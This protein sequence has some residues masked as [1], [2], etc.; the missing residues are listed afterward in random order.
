MSQDK[1]KQRSRLAALRYDVN[2]V[3]LRFI[4]SS[5]RQANEDFME[6][7]TVGKLPE[8]NDSIMRLI[9]SKLPEGSP[10]LT[11]DQVYVHFHEAA[12]NNFVSDRSM[13]M[14]EK[15]LK[16]IGQ[17][18]AAGVAFMNSHRTGGM[19][20][21]SELPF[22][23]TF[24][25]QYQ[26][27]F[28]DNKRPIR[29]SIIGVYMLKGTHP[30][31]QNGPSTDDLH[32]G[33]LSGTIFDISVGLSGGEYICEVCSNPLNARDDDGEYL[34]NH[35]PGT[36]MGMTKE[37]ILAQKKADPQNTKGLASYLLDDAHLNESSAVYDGAVPGA[38]IKK[39]MSFAQSSSISKEQF[40]ELVT[41][42]YQE[43]G[44][45]LPF[46]I[47]EIVTLNLEGDC[48]TNGE[49]DTIPSNG[50]KF[51]N[52][53]NQNEDS[54]EETQEDEVEV[55]TEDESLETPDPAPVAEAPV[56]ETAPV[57]GKQ[58]NAN[59]HGRAAKYFVESHLLSNRIL[60]TESESLTNLYLAC[61]EHGIEDELEAFVEARPGHKFTND[62]IAPRLDG[63]NYSTPTLP[64]DAEDASIEQAR[65]D[66]SKFLNGDKAKV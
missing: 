13:H 17:D 39:V 47:S 56:V 1:C 58:N 9:N 63:K 35:Y 11:S 62:V 55:V 23:R 12:N 7:K 60:P 49:H 38:G 44:S 27:G 36:H 3:P 51:M 61:A 34:C 5:T 31:G 66:T 45:L 16:N 22:G 21:P 43:F 18:A 52:N 54:Q 4:G 50:E 8:S 33:I 25:G 40:R 28:D 59:K 29:R 41:E 26:E 30:N 2:A 42:A 57:A 37:E 15:T 6:L 19:S 32:Q 20:S 64:Q 48:Q 53:E 10:P 46:D 24:A 65:K 14:S